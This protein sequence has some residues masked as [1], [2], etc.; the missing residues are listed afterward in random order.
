MGE[1]RGQWSPS[2]VLLVSTDLGLRFTGSVS[3][4]GWTGRRPD[5]GA[6]CRVWVRESRYSPWLQGAVQIRAGEQLAARAEGHLDHGV[7]AIAPVRCTGWQSCAD[8]LAGQRVPQSHGTVSVGAGQELA[9]GAEGHIADSIR[10]AA[11][12]L[13]LRVGKNC[14]SDWL[15][16]QR[17]P[18]PH[19]AAATACAREQLA[20]R[21]EGH[22][23]RLRIGMDGR[24]G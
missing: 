6:E 18:Q 8:L 21:A 10:E 14:F 23:D 13:R 4:P 11:I 20:V 7:R 19:L 3:A 1:S 15:F 5:I 12:G 22:A 9:V 16:G 2:S 24:P 17:I